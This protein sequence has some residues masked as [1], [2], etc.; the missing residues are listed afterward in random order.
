MS[1]NEENWIEASG[2]VRNAII[3]MRQAGD[4]IGI[5]AEGVVE[6]IADMIYVYLDITIGGIS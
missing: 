2:K 6:E 4:K 1:Q 3:E 5:D